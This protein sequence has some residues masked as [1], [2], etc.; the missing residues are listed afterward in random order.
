MELETEEV[1]GIVVGDANC[2]SV[3]VLLY[4]TG[5]LGVGMVVMVGR[6]GGYLQHDLRSLGERS[7]DGEERA[8]H[9]DVQRGRK[10]YELSPV[11]VEAAHEHR[12]RER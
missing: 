6:R 2:L 4:R 9:A 1:A 11:G 7:M 8:A 12:D 5:N 10:I 3:K